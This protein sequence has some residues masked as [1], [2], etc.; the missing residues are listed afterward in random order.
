[1]APEFT[2]IIRIV[3]KKRVS[4]TRVTFPRQPR[5]VTRDALVEGLDPSPFSEERRSGNILIREHMHLFLARAYSTLDT[6][7]RLDLFEVLD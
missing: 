3:V 6:P 1:V 2:D 5:E 7:D 4:G